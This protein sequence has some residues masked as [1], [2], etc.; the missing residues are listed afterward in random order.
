MPDPAAPYLSAA[1]GPAT[2]CAASKCGAGREEPDE[3]LYARLGVPPSATPS[4]LRRA[5]LQLLVT[6]HPDK[7]G[8]PE[9]FHA[10]QQAYSLLSD[11]A[12][13]VV[14][15]E[16]LAQVAGAGASGTGLGQAA[17]GAS[18]RV[19]RSSGGVTVV[20]HGQTGPAQP[21]GGAAGAGQGPGGG[22]AAAAAGG[23]Q[24]AGAAVAEL[25]A[26]I[27]ALRL[28]QRGSGAKSSG[29]ETSGSGMG[30]AEAQP[31]AALYA[32]RA[33]A[34]QQ[35]GRLHHARFDA[36][37]AA[38]LCPDWAPARALLGELDG[39]LARAEAAGGEAGEAE[40]GD[41]GGSSSSSSDD[42]L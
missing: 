31:L 41:R 24:G 17:A 22:A 2:S 32:Q 13:R 28:Q 5:W 23:Q 1:A 30:A 38:R 3:T 26:Q 29:A 18:G 36:E 11:P 42:E 34:H 21:Q 9:R 7:G 6:A 20:V 40:G 33:G 37:E 39:Q 25:S 35:A 4:E 16:K 15:D 19:V 8:C 27:E 14:Y 10:L 12:Q